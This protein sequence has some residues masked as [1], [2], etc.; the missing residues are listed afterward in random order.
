LTD[1]WKIPGIKWHENLCSGSQI[2]QCKRWANMIKLIV[3]LHDF[4]NTPKNCFSGSLI[5]I[6]KSK[7]SAFLAVGTGRILGL[8]FQQKSRPAFQLILMLHIAVIENSSLL[9]CWPCWLVNSY[10]STQWPLQMIW[11]FK[12][13]NITVPSHNLI[14]KISGNYHFS[15]LSMVQSMSNTAV[16]ACK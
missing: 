13:S 5:V 7:N 10:Q 9:E 8:Q 3:A 16:V 4:V 15:H 11:F 2:F 12:T 1:F 6:F 14:S